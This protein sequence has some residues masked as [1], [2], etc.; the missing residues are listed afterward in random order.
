[1]IEAHRPTGMPVSIQM[2]GKKCACSFCF[3]PAMAD[4]K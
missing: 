1:M 3:R 2:D 4:G